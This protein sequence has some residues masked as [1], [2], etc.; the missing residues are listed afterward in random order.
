M[1]G[2]MGSGSEIVV[3]VLLGITLLGESRRRLLQRE[4]TY[5]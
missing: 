2:N 1:H 5:I 4:Y 3:A